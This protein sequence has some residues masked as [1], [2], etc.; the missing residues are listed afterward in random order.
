[1]WVFLFQTWAVL[2]RVFASVATRWFYNGTWLPVFTD[3]TWVDEPVGNPADGALMVDRVCVPP[4][5]GPHFLAV[6]LRDPI[7]NKGKIYKG[8]LEIP[9]YGA[10]QFGMSDLELAGE[11]RDT[12]GSGRFLRVISVSYLLLP[13][14]FLGRI[15]SRCITKSTI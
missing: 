15:Q 3:T 4:D 2:K 6:K 14:C 8:E 12:M 9:G 7:S 10:G 13:E 5:A 11:V 1:M